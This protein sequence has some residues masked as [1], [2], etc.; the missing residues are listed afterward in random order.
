MELEQRL[1]KALEQKTL[2]IYYQPKLDLRTGKVTGMEALA[3]WN[4]SDLGSVSPAEFIPLAEET[5]MIVPL[6][7]WVLESACYQNMEWQEMGCDPIHVCVNISSRQFLQDDF[8]FMIE[9]TI[10]DSG[11][12]PE[13]LNLEITEGIAL[14]NI[15]DA[16][17]KLVRLKKL[18]ISISLDDFGT[19]YSSLSY[20]K[21]LPIDFLK[22]DRAF[23]NG[24]ATNKQDAA[25]ID[26]IISLAHSFDFRVVAEGVEDERQMKMLTA[27]NCDEIQGFYFAKPMPPV[28]FKQFLDERMERSLYKM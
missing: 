14:N 3:R 16:I 13:F 21:S 1:R 11:L 5:G 19:G 10:R 17:W 27:K 25:I 4:D 24:I 9:Q 7:K 23:I 2:E 22:I 28:L 20:I 8:I 26:S 6:G 15:E 18:G 12:T